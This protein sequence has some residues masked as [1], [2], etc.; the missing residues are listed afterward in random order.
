MREI[1]EIILSGFGLAC[2]VILGLWSASGARENFGGGDPR[3]VVID[4]FAGMWL[5][6][7]IAGSAGWVA[8]ALAF[9]LF[10]FFD[11]AKPFPIRR[12]ERIGG[13]AG[14]M[15]DDLVAGLCAG[16]LTRLLMYLAGP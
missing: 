5:S 15:A 7:L 13:A 1:D 14:I 10:R 4:E 16:A 8:I 6:F 3:P 11:A 12:V 9:G 2:L